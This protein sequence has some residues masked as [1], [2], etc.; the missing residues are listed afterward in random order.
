MYQ[1][2]I[3]VFQLGQSSPYWAGFVTDV[4][5]KL[6]STQND[7]GSWTC[8]DSY[9]NKGGQGENG[10]AKRYWGDRGN[11][12]MAILILEVY[13]RYGDVHD[14][15]SRYG[16]IIPQKKGVRAKKRKK[17]VSV[18]KSLKSLGLEF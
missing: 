18:Q 8:K 17:S 5:K 11:T 3:G 4:I 16:K 10:G 14:M 2:G 7:D 9:F 13:F 15:Y 1:Q 12:A 6:I